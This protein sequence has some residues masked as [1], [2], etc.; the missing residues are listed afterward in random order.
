MTLVGTFPW[1]AP[2]L[3]Q[4]LKSNETCD[5]YSFGVLMWEMLTRE[6]PFKGMEGFQVAWNVVEKKQR[7]PI[8]ETTPDAFRNLIATC[9]DQGEF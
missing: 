9:W 2:E 7:P 6:V 5:T 4:G 3:I 1:M 8:P